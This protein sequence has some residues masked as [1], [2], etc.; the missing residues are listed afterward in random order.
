MLWE[1]PNKLVPSRWNGSGR[2]VPGHCHVRLDVREVTSETGKSDVGW[3][4][5]L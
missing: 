2:K 3:G 1:Q 5:G 4:N